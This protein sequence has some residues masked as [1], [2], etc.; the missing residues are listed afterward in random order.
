MLSE[1]RA[2]L[3]KFH[4]AFG[5]YGILSDNNKLLVIKKGAGPYINRYDL[6]GGSLDEGE[7]LTEALVREFNEETGFHVED[8]HNIGVT[9]FILPWVWKGFTHVHHIAVFYEVRKISGEI[10][11]PVQFDGQDSLEAKWVQLNE[12][13]LN[14]SSPLVLKA[15]RWLQN[16][17][18]DTVT[19][20]YDEWKPLHSMS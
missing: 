20:R 5:V 2:Y 9:D 19:E 18:F 8:K 16:T 3:K 12:L 11:K 15:T 6:P 4:R 17:E 7:S 1:R 14:N 13:S 10:H